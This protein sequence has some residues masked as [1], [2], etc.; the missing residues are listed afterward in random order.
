MDTHSLI[1]WLSACTWEAVWLFVSLLALGT[2]LNSPQLHHEEPNSSCCFGR[3]QRGPWQHSAWRAGGGQET[4]GSWGAGNQASLGSL[5]H[6]SGCPHVHLDAETSRCLSCDPCRLQ[7]MASEACLGLTDSRGP[8]AGETRP[9]TLEPA[10]GCC[11]HSAPF[12][13]FWKSPLV[14]DSLM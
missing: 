7:S 2:V 9:W 4:I 10:S 12:Q 6:L 14:G 3:A 11:R 1:E 13:P 8:S 5:G